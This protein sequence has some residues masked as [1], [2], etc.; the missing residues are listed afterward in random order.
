MCE[1]A[2]VRRGCLALQTGALLLDESFSILLFRPADFLFSVFKKP[3]NHPEPL[4][5]LSGTLSGSHTFRLVGVE[6]NLGP[7]S[8]SMHQKGGGEV[9]VSKIRA[10]SE[11]R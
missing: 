10:R 7:G 8:T 4:E 9:I 2:G 6:L 11:F 3:S 1:L 5:F